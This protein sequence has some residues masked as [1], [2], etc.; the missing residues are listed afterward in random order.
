MVAIDFAASGDAAQASASLSLHRLRYLDWS[1]STITSLAVSP[2]HAASDSATTSSASSSRG[3]LAVGRQNGDIEL[4]VW[5]ENRAAQ[6][7]EVVERSFQTYAKGWMVHTVLPGQLNSKIEQLCFANPPAAGDNGIHRLRLFSI[8]GG[9]IVTEHFLPADLARLGAR[10]SADRN[11]AGNSGSIGGLSSLFP[12]RNRPEVDQ[13]VP[14]A[15]RTL[16]SLGG[17]VW[18]MAVSPTSRYLAIGCEDGY[19]RII[20]LVD[21]K[22]E[23]LAGSTGR[24][25]ELTARLGKAQGRIISLAWGPPKRVQ[26]SPTADAKG[27]RRSVNESDSSDSSDSDSESD[28]DDDEGGAGWRESFLVG[29]LGNSSAVVWDLASGRITSKLTVQKARG[30]ST[31]I[32]CVSTLPDGTIVT[33]DSTGRVTLFDPKTRVPIP[34]ATFRSHTS[35]ADVLTLCVGPDGKSLYSAGVDQKVAEYALIPS[36]SSKRGRWVQIAARRLHAHDIRSLAIDP[37]YEPLLS[38]EALSRGL[39]TPVRKLPILISGGV[40][41]NLILTPASSPSGVT[42]AISAKAAAGLPNSKNRRR[43]LLMTAAEQEQALINPISSNAVT[44]FA[45]STQRRVP[46]VPS[47]S[48][49]GSVGGGSIASVCK[50]KGWIVLRREQSIGIWDLGIQN[51]NHGGVNEFGEE[52]VPAPPQ[53]TKL[54]EMELKVNSNLCSVAISPDGRFLAASDMYETKLFVLRERISPR[55]GQTD[56]EPRKVKSFSRIFG[57]DDDVAPG[58]SALCFSPDSSRL[59]LASWSGCYVHVVELPSAESGASGECRL[60]RSFGQHRQ[61]P[62]TA[63]AADGALSNISGRQIAGRN[64][65]AG[66]KVNGAH[67]DGNGRV[68]DAEDGALARGKQSDRVERTTSSMIHH[69]QI[70][71]DGAWLSTISSDLQHHIFSLDS[72]TFERTLP[73]PHAL[74]SGSSFHPSTNASRSGMLTL[75]YSDNKVEMWDVESGKELSSDSN[76][77]C[78]AEPEGEKRKSTKVRSPSR[79]CKAEWEA[80][81]AGLKVRLHERLMSIRESA[82]GALWLGGEGAA[83]AQGNVGETLVVWGPTWICTAR[84][85]PQGHAQTSP[86]A[87]NHPDQSDADGDV[88]ML[89]SQHEGESGLAPAY[90]HVKHTHKYQP[91]LLV[92]SVATG[93]EVKRDDLVVVERPFYELAQGLPP[94]FHQGARYGA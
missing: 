42:V 11:A 59:V 56:L 93:K 4:C 55:Q 12:G 41:F 48:R 83:G 57:H 29:G 72:L 92:D 87:R 64:G 30:E 7:A 13:H 61:R 65:N 26:R 90:W 8:S 52:L 43:N 86:T 88:D 35:G 91:L 50:G 85:D 38:V 6:R 60:L 37:P 54:L 45:D 46:F 49:S 76:L 81:M 67:G 40:D 51:D 34:G 44:T 66:Q 63:S 69:A 77:G 74:P 1:P 73:S 53:W 14:G 70:S 47:T 27:K 10:S 58:A 23:H 79:S 62:G 9:A 94:A 16:T 2:V 18:S 68:D 36:T 21:N 19:A 32:W 20:D 15:I 71:S 80:K 22:F 82:V 78:V 5:L 25:A 89:A 33:G 24:G 84:H 17:A 3:I 75:V 28:D 31:I 39:D